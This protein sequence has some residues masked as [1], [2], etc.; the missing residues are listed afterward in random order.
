M[1]L[2]NE[3]AATF[4]HLLSSMQI[5]NTQLL[6]GLDAS[7]PGCCFAIIPLSWTAHHNSG[8]PWAAVQL[9]FLGISTL[10]SST[11]DSGIAWARGIMHLNLIDIK[12][13]L[14]IGKRG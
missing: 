5:N 3:A 11:L 12:P 4:R 7:V 6:P 1:E 9:S 14:L 8:L 2:A 10:C 13:A